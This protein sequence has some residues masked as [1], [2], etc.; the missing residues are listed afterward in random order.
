M[1]MR[2][3]FWFSTTLFFLLTAIPSAHARDMH[4]RMGLGYNGQFASTQQTNGVPAISIRYGLTSRMQVEVIGGFYSGINGTGVAALKFM[5]TI[6]PETYMNFYWLAA[7]GYVGAGGKSGTEWLGGLGTEFFIPGIESVGFA[8][9]TGLSYENLT[10]SSFVL[11]TFGLSFINV[12][13]HFYF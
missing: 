12:G 5:Q 11:K 1:K 6:H 9:E 2:L 8:F 3:N 4:G 7:G 13:M 10:S